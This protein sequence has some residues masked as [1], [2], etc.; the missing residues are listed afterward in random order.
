MLPIFRYL[1]LK[2]L[3]HCVLLHSFFLFPSP[4]PNASSSQAPHKKSKD[5]KHSNGTPLSPFRSAWEALRVK[6]KPGSCRVGNISSVLLL[7]SA[8]G[9][10]A[11]SIP[12]SLTYLTLT[13]KVAFFHL[14]PQLASL[15]LS[16]ACSLFPSLF[17]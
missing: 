3:P 13:P 7:P 12:L 6:S 4:F 9:L 1:W 15:P 10:F 16:L 5:W 2:K 11:P 8:G 17:S 14:L